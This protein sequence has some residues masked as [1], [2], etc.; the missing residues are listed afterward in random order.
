[1]VVMVARQHHVVY[2]EG[3]VVWKVVWKVVLK[4]VV[5]GI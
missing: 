5:V 2:S 3:A 4:V 1:M